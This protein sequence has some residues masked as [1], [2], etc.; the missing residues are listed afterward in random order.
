MASRVTDAEYAMKREIVHTTATI[1][2]AAGGPSYSVPRLCEELVNNADVPLSLLCLRSGNVTYPRW[3]KNFRYGPGPWRL[4][5]S[6]EMYRWLKEKASSGE[7]GII[8]THG[9]WMMP[10]IYAGWVARRYRIPF[11]VAPRGTLSEYSMASGSKVKRLF[12]PLVQRPVLEAVTCF[13]A[14]CEAEVLDIRRLGFRQ[15]VAIIPNGIDLPDR[16]GTYSGKFRSVLYLGRIHPEKGVES[17]IRA[18]AI[19]EQEAP[20]WMLRVVGFGDPGYVEYIKR[21]TQELNIERCEF[22]GPLY[23]DAKM[24]AYQ[25]CDLYALFSLGDNFAMTVAEA[26]AVG[27]PVISTKGA[28]WQGLVTRRAGWWVDG[29]VDAFAGA[30]KA[31]VSTPRDELLEMGERGRQW[32]LEEFSWFRIGRDMKSLYQWILLGGKLPS[33]VVCD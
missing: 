10:N 23:G 1:D 19:I 14:T 26:L 33:F 13:H 30:L 18:W 32:M 4:G 29:S 7:L 9:M 5:R 8:H 6:P 21:L 27:R 11:I 12:W 3:A 28:P 2:G 16:R 15:P 31:A 22:V 20:G 24:R 17:L 25:E